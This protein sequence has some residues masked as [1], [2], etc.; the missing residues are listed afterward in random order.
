MTAEGPTSIVLQSPTPTDPAKLQTF[1]GPHGRGVHQ[2][3]PVVP[4]QNSGRFLGRGPDK[5]AP[6]SENNT[7]Q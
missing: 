4:C 1:V 7:A 5:W 2:S 6:H 3:F